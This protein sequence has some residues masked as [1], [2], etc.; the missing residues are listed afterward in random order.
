[1][2]PVLF[3]ML[4]VCC[5]G[6]GTRHAPATHRPR[7]GHREIVYMYSYIHRCISEIPRH[8]PHHNT[9]S[10]TPH[11]LL[12]YAL[13]R[14]LFFAVFGRGTSHHYPIDKEHTK[15]ICQCRA[16]KYLPEIKEM[17]I[18]PATIHRHL[19]YLTT[20]PYHALPY[21]TIPCLTIHYH[22]MPYQHQTRCFVWQD[23]HPLNAPPLNNIHNTHTH[24]HTHAQHTHT[25]TH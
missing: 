11:H 10:R 12:S 9:L 16:S 2:R 1:M 3:L 21:H 17:F 13:S 14:T 19:P 24:T 25:H 8:A 7:T 20:L 22:I 5:A 18:Q 6:T 23:I 15:G 4:L